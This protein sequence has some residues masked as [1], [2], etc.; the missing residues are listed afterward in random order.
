MAHL[1]GRNGGVATCLA[2]ARDCE[3]P[4]EPSR[5]RRHLLDRAADGLAR[6]LH[7]VPADAVRPPARRVRSECHRQ[8]DGI[9][10]VELDGGIGLGHRLIKPHPDP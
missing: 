9:A 8:A 1:V 6:A 7:E 5:A 10:R 3:V 4:Q 2:A